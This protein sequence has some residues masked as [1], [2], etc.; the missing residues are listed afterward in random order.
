M[1]FGFSVSDFVTVPTF[2]WTVYK[3]CKESSDD[4]RNISTEVA[5][6]H[7]VLK[8]TE[9]CLAEHI[10]DPDQERRLLVIGKG[11]NDV[12]KDLNKLLEKYE[13]LGLQSQR[14]WDR[15]MWGLEDI[16][17]IRERLIANT[18]LLTAFNTILTRCAYLR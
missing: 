18:N 6:L 13:S 14:T 1:S 2:A 8:E 5:S 3:S 16:S 10:L 12:L 17:K 9:E 7:V 4:F 15:M 11:C